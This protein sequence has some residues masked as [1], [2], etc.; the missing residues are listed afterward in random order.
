MSDASSS[1]SVTLEVNDEPRTS[2]VPAGT[3]LLSL[4][5]DHLSLTGAHRG[6][7]SGRCGACTVLLDGDPV[8]SC[9][10]L[11]GQAD[12]SSVT[13]VEG[14]ADGDELHPVQSALCEMH[15]LQCGFC[16]PGIVV[17]A[18]SLLDENPSPT[19]EEIQRALQG[20]LCRCTGYTK[21][22]QSIETAADAFE[23]NDG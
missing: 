22:I 4:L 14:L 1:I 8:K 23:E 6:C 9:T 19:R 18:A 2:T 13:T 16:T 3:T 20:N 21:I 5:R 7:D 12:G 15:G 11:A 10:V 17:S